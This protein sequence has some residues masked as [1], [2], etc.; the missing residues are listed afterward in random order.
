MEAQEQLGASHYSTA[1][2]RAAR[3]DGYRIGERREQPQDY[4]MF[5]SW[6]DVPCG[7]DVYGS[8]CPVLPHLAQA[9]SFW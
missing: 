9:F 2:D 5:P 3:G 6:T 4:Q 7:A 8:P 1:G